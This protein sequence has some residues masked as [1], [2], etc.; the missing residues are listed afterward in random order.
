[1]KEKI[2]LDDNLIERLR[3]NK[4]LIEYIAEN[5]REIIESNSDYDA[6]IIGDLCLF[7]EIRKAIFE[8]LDLVFSKMKRVCAFS[9]YMGKSEIQKNIDTFFKYEITSDIAI[10]FDNLKG[11]NICDSQGL[12]DLLAKHIDKIYDGIGIYGIYNLIRMIPYFRNFT[13]KN[14]SINKIDKFLA[15]KIEDISQTEFKYE[16]FNFSFFMNLDE[17]K[18]QISKKGS[19]FFVNFP[20]DYNITIEECKKMAESIFGEFT[21][22]N[23]TKMKFGQNDRQRALI[24]QIIID[25]LLEQSGE[26]ASINDI[27]QQ[28]QGSFSTAYRVGNYI[29]KFG[30]IRNNITIPNHRRIL[31]SILKTEV[32]EHYFTSKMTNINASCIE[33]QNLVEKDW[34]KDMSHEEINEILFQIY[35]DLRDEGLLWLDIKPS[36]VGRLL[37]PNTSNV[38]FVDIDGKTKQIIPHEDGNGLIGKVNGK[39][40]KAGDYVIIDNDFIITEDEFPKQK[41]LP[42]TIDL[43]FEFE[44]RYRSKLKQAER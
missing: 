43:A 21:S 3:Y 35:S 39:P 28:G 25:E 30:D 8:N 20:L 22:E 36:N 1:M 24:F 32:K 27:K 13:T 5:F 18:R 17:F 11:L 23:F 6:S 26:D 37:K 7:L 15:E 40:L 31:Q 38:L 2:N 9:F 14:G 12:I 29:L 34:C 42:K 4:E 44:L 10:L 19:D 33:V 41:Y 16:T